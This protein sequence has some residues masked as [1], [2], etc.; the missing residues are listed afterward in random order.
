MATS[1]ALTKQFWSRAEREAVVLVPYV[2]G[3]LLLAGQAAVHVQQYS[4][5]F[6]EVRWIGPLFLVDAVASLVV[7]AA[8]TIRRFR[9]LAA[10]TGIVIAVLALGSLVVSYGRGL[11]GWQETGFR[12]P[13]ELTVIFEVGAVVFLAIA[14]ALGDVSA[15]RRVRALP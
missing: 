3:A 8:L 10:L 11:F 1:P 13:V 2:L 14:L 15:P 9:R 5:L 7:I 12:T 4:S 6:H